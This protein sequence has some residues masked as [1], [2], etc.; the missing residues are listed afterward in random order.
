[1]TGMLLL[2]GLAL[3]VGAT[4]L[5]AE[6]RWFARRPLVERL[7]PY[8]PGGMARHRRIGVL[9]IE[10]FREAVGPLARHLGSHLSRLFGINEDLDRR[11][12]R[13][14]AVLDVTGFRVRQIGWSLAGL[15]IGTLLAVVTAP[16]AP[17][18]LALVFVLGGM[19]LAFLVLEQQVTAASDR[20]K[21][22]VQLELP[23]V[24]E[25]IGMLLGSGY[26][27]LAALDRVARR[28]SGAVA[29]DLGTVT[30]RIRQGVAEERALF[31]WA[32]LADVDGVDRL[33]AV[34]AL[35]REA[36]DLGRLIATEARGIRRDVQREL[37]SVMDK[38]GQ[39]VWIPV[40]FAALLPG[41]IFIAIPFTR[42]LAAF[43]T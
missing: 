26:S 7:G 35:N 42:A 11:L 40:T 32:E 1:M 6:L 3:W 30:A 25:Q 41:V 21:R 24:A 39:Q 17:P 14:H 29:T 22:A 4:L 15:A 31:E 20:W 38:R 12:R 16:V 43:V 37:V 34:L 23:V 33:V 9:S 19:L 13:V 8:V 28:G 10:S 27:L 5:L 18:A 36:S 2:S